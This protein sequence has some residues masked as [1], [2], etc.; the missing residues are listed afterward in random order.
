MGI[1]FLMGINK[2]F[3]T[4]LR[5]IQSLPTLQRFLTIKENIMKKLICAVSMAG[6][7]LG[8]QLPVMSAQAVEIHTDGKIAQKIN[9]NM[10]SAY[11]LV[12]I[13]GIGEK[14]AQAIITYRKA[15]GPFKSL[16]ELKNV[17]G[18]SER[19]FKRIEPDLVVRVAK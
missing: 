7:L 12:G 9:I 6:V 2:C 14:K 3:S 10:A 8:A 19:L 15:H 17:H 1:Y 13:K 18:I 5:L 11:D 16:D 4:V